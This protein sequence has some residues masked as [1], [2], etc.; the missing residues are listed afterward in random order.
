MEFS[1]EL[2]TLLRA[3]IELSSRSELHAYIHG[4]AHDGTFNRSHGTLRISQAD[5]RWLWCLSLVFSQIGRRSWI[6]REGRRDVWVIETS[7][8]VQGREPLRDADARAY[9]RGY[10]DAE[11]GLPTQTGA[12][13][14]IQFVQEDFD[15]LAELRQL[16]TQQEIQCGRLHNPSV[17]KDPQLWRFYVSSCSH[18]RFMR[19]VGSWHPA[20]R[21]RIAARLNAEKALRGGNGVSMNCACR[22]RHTTSALLRGRGQAPNGT[23]TRPS[24]SASTR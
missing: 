5:V 18:S 17:A 7:H 24:E 15:D 8:R 22:C 19:L 10:F 12:R 11:G 4:A 23:V 1:R 9:A 21:G 3:E 16:L 14:Y 20:K 6:Y 13:L 2:P